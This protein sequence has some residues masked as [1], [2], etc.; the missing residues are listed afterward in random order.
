MY[1]DFILSFIMHTPCSPIAKVVCEIVNIFKPHILIFV[2]M[3]IQCLF[4]CS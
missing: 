3:Y 4:I 2:N 1:S